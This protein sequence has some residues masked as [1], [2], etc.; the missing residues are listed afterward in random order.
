ML[1]DARRCLK[2]LEDACRYSLILGDTF[3]CLKMPEDTFRC[4]LMFAEVCWSPR[5]SKCSS[6]LKSLSSTLRMALC[7]SSDADRFIN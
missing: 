5:V 4:L 3:R 6:L 2:I 1:E 7:S